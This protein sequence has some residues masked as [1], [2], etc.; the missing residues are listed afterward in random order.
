MS[1][2]IDAYRTVD[3]GTASSRSV[4]I[5]L[6]STAEG[7]LTRAAEQLGEGGDATEA[8]HKAQMIVGGLVTALDMEAGEMAQRLLQLYLFVLDRIDGS[9]RQ[10]RDAGLGAARDVL[11][12]L[13]EGFE[14]MSAE[15]AR[16]NARPLATAAVGL[17][18]RG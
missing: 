11:G 1:S 9:H 18:L 6:Y 2:S 15:D 10:G 5:R 13:R 7:H 12:K 8:L 14:G 3:H 16:R 17:H 4:L